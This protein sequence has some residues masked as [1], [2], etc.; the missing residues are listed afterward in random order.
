M[1]LQPCQH[2]GV[3]LPPATS[4]G[5]LCDTFPACLPAPSTSL[6]GR[7]VQMREEA[8]DAYNQAANSSRTLEAIREALGGSGG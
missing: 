5:A 3:A 8:K 1:T 4:C 6:V 7:L 2:T